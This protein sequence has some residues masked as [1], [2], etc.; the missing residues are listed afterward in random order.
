MHAQTHRKRRCYR[1]LQTVACLT[2]TPGPSCRVRSS[3][4]VYEPEP[5]LGCCEINKDH[6]DM[7]VPALPLWTG[8]SG[9]HTDVGPQ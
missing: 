9:K 1:A 8:Y 7:A 2:G 6:M 5:G 4:Q 3:V